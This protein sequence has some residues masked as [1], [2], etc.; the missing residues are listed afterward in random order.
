MNVQVLSIRGEKYAL[1]PLADFN[2]LMESA[3]YEQKTWYSLDEVCRE[4]GIEDTEIEFTVAQVA[5][6]LGKT[7][8]EIRRLIKSGVLKATK[9]GGRYFVNKAEIDR[10]KAG[11][12]PSSAATE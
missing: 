7:P 5:D 6:I 3:A 12:T 2:E 9:A 4:F 10:S 8:Q 1:L 11:F